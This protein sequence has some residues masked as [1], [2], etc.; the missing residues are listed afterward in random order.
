MSELPPSHFDHLHAYDPARGAPPTPEIETAWKAAQEIPALRARHEA[1]LDF[2]AAMREQVASIPVPEG[3][4]GR[5]KAAHAARQGP[6]PAPVEEHRDK[7]WWLHFG[8][9]SSVSAALILLTLAW[10]FL[11]NPY[12]ARATPELQSFLTEVESTL[13][14][15]PESM[16]FADSYPDLTNH[17][18]E[19]QAPLPLKLPEGLRQESGF[20]CREVKI[21]G[22]TVAMLCFRREDETFHLFTFSREA[23]PRQ[24][25]IAKPVIYE[26]NRRNCATW[27][28]RDHIYLLATKAAR[29]ELEDVL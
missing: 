20:A 17:L 27:T 5:I 25:D 24:Q 29:R 28:D 11:F 19:Q 2:D 26:R 8:L 1:E 13:D 12:E 3:L 10:T 22:H 9:L 6:T 15:G 14:Q 21:D 7:S 4:A 18:R 16:F 23:L